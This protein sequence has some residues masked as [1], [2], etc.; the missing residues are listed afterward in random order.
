MTFTLRICLWKSPNSR[1]SFSNLVTLAKL[2]LSSNKK[3]FF[4]IYLKLE[5]SLLAYF[6]QDKGSRSFNSEIIFNKMQARSQKWTNLCWGNAPRL[7]VWKMGTEERR[8]SISVTRPAL[9]RSGRAPLFTFALPQSGRYK[10]SKCP[11][12]SIKHQCVPI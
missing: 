4:Y 8:E 6:L 11:A 10:L 7:T 3:E 12:L 1:Q 5:P 2:E 9:F